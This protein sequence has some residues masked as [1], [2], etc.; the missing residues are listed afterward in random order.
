MISRK[1]ACP[2]GLAGAVLAI[3]VSLTACGFEELQTAGTP[4]LSTT[5]RISFSASDD[6][7]RGGHGFVCQSDGSCLVSDTYGPA[8]AVFRVAPD[9]TVM[10]LAVDRPFRGPAGLRFDKQGNLFVTEVQ[11]GN[12]VKVSPSGH[13]EVVAGSFSGPW[14]LAMA[15]DGSLLVACDNGDIW[16]LK[17]GQRRRLY[18]AP[19]EHPFDVEV[20]G[21]GNI[22]VSLQGAH[23]RLNP[24]RRPLGKV[25]KLDLQGRAEVYASGFLV[26]EGMAVDSEDR[27]YV[28]D[29][30]EG[31][32]Y[33]VT[34]PEQRKM[35]QNGLAIPVHLAIRGQDLLAFLAAGKIV[36]INKNQ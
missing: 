30:Q 3:L 17:D 5:T 19:G 18:A 34:G 29:T 36:T 23:D 32:V 10:K 35:L 25:L 14:N 6:R 31:A 12:I 11:D 15:S 7:F 22:Y 4:S 8:Q 26:A 27:L 33:E 2:T 1:F 16:R 9:Q 21:R 24:V 20:D 28:A 13:A